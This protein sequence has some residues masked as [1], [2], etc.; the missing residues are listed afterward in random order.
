MEDVRSWLVK[1]KL[2]IFEDVFM[3]NGYDELDVIAELDET[4]LDAMNI[5]LPGHRKKILLRV[6][7]LKEQAGSF[8]GKQKQ[9]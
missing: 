3:Q 4:D 9:V 1:N 8:E 5:N 2:D 7:Q 6:K